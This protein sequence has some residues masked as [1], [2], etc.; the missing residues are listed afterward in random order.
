MEKLV[1]WK[2]RKNQKPLIIRGARQ[3]GKTWLMKRFAEQEYEDFIY[4]SFDDNQPV[5]RIF[6]P[7]LAPRRI[8][9]EI[10]AV[11]QKPVVPGKTLMIFDEIQESP[12]ALKALKYFNEE[13]P[14]YHIICAGSLLGIALHPG[15]SFPVGKVS[16]IDMYPMSFAE[17]LTAVGESRYAEMIKDGDPAEWRLFREALIG[18]LKQ[19]FFLGGMPEVVSSFASERDYGQ[20]RELQRQIIDLYD[21]DFSKH[22][23]GVHIPRIRMLWNSIPS[24][25]GRE[26]KKFMYNNIGQGARAREYE[27]AMLWILDTGIAH[28]VNAVSDAKIPLK[29]YENFKAFK[30]YLCDIGL[31]S[32]MSGLDISTLIDES[33]L[34][35]EFRGAM[36]EQY[37]LQELIAAGGYTP[38]YWSNADGRAEV[39]F[40]IESNGRVVAVEA[41]AGIN[42]QAKSLITYID[43]YEPGTAVR[44]SL[45]DY[46]TSDNRGA[47]I[48]DVPLFAIGALPSLLHFVS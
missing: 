29:A 9:R 42:L 28:R 23:P 14:E 18:L 32:C 40:L 4:I 15:T 17:Y 44:T 25:L 16:F 21:L 30:L 46:N 13:A 8:V 1:A 2:H 22:A 34:F 41:K 37:V 11:H 6:E 35:T 31:L 33:A 19:Y 20:C 45:A 3:V 27:I 38:Y 36:T 26:K 10:E 47:T 5:G 48:L 7:D 24:Q 43:K 12:K 39:D